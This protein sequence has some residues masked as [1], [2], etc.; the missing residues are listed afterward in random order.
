MELAIN[1]VEEFW[2]FCWIFYIYFLLQ[3]RYCEIEKQF[4]YKGNALKDYTAR[5][6]IA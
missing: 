1:N 5:L 6:K 3:S 4:N 2:M